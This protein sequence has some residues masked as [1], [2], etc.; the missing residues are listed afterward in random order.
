MT[1]S[2]S[3]GVFLVRNRRTYVLNKMK[4]LDK[5]EGVKCKLIQTNFVSEI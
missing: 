5:F 2:R 1:E 3:P 4:R